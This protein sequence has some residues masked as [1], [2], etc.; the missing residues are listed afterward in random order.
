MDGFVVVAVGARVLDQVLLDRIIFILVGVVVTAEELVH[1]V[2]VVRQALEGVVL[3]LLV[4]ERRLADGVVVALQEGQF[5]DRA[6]G[7]VRVEALGLCRCRLEEL[8]IQKFFFPNLK[9]NYGA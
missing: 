2:V 7:P 6:R 5:F 1:R 9:S 3:C 8:F 4:P